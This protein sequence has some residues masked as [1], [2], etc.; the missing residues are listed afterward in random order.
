MLKLLNSFSGMWGT[1][2][3]K[4]ARFIFASNNMECENSLMSLFK[5]IA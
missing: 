3:L 4:H 5:V 1:K 2:L